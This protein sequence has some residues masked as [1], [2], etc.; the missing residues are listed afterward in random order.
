[1]SGDCPRLMVLHNNERGAVAKK[2]F[3]PLHFDCLFIFVFG[4]GIA[5]KKGENVEDIK[6]C[7]LVSSNNNL[8]SFPT[9]TR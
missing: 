5:E 6:N 4:N 3:Y 1:M 8:H 2:I 9:L 7:L